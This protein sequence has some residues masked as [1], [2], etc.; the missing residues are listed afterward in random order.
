MI[1]ENTETSGEGE[2]YAHFDGMCWPLAGSRLSDLEWQLRYGKPTRSQLLMA[3]S[4]LS[5]YR[6]MVSDPKAKRETVIREIR[7]KQTRA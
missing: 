7:A 1:S 5:A 3:A 4:V 6:Q 2:F